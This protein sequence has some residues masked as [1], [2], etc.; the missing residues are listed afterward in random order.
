M[1]SESAISLRSR[2]DEHTANILRRPVLKVRHKLQRD[3]SWSDQMNS[4]F[5]DTVVH[6]W[7]CPPIYV[8][9]GPIDDDPA[10][11]YVFDGAHK[12]EALF[13]FIDG[14]YSIKKTN[15]FSP[16]KDSEGKFYKELTRE[17]QDKITN[18]KFN[19]NMLSRE[20]ANDSEALKVLWERLNKAGRPL[21]SYELSLPAIA[22]LN[23]LVIKPCIEHFLESHVY[24]KD[25]STRG[26]AEKVIQLILVTSESPLTDPIMT[27]FGSK[28]ALIE[29]W[30][31]AR[32][33]TTI[34]Q[35][36]ENTHKHA[37]TWTANLK[38][39]S[40]YMKTLSENNC[41]V[42]GE[43]KEI[44]DTARRGTELPFLL[45]RL[46]FHF[47]RPDEFNR[48][49]P[50]L[51]KQVKDKFF[52]KVA[53]DEAGRNGALQRRMLKEIDEIVADYARQRTPRLFKPDVIAAKKAAQGSVCALCGDAILPNQPHV[54]DHIVPYASGGETV[55]ENCQVTHARCNSIKGAKA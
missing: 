28:L 36:K 11:E 17:I 44:L 1:E 40:K 23:A 3:N 53:R 39:A 47:K 8:F 29:S 31:N 35:T 13:K 49:C 16:L 25:K 24:K 15:S 55:P 33:G 9:P 18:Y 22:E 45:G 46:V 38:L 10:V 27:G 50:T 30:Q 37:A 14:K 43:G 51:A 4:D 32:L 42:D 7:T 41:F 2:T 20:T 12:L 54:G 21:N 5:V 48:I 26:Q 34:T 52:G 19:I 6:G